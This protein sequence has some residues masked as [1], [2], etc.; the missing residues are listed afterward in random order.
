[1]KKKTFSKKIKM[2][3]TDYQKDR[4]TNWE[5]PSYKEFLC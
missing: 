4:K 5:K 2:T 1:M 3:K